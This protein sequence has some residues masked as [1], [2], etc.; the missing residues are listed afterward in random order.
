MEMTAALLCFC[1]KPSGLT[2]PF[3]DSSTICMQHI[4]IQYA[5]L[6]YDIK[7]RARVI[8][9]YICVVHVLIKQLRTLSYGTREAR[10]KQAQ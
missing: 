6:L 2:S 10:E 7:L 9:G 4:L 3:V 5:E 1:L 8:V